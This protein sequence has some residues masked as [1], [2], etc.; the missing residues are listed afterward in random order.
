M[1]IDEP[2]T[3]YAKQYDPAE[4]EEE[5][6]GLKPEEL[7]VDELEMDKSKQPPRSR[8]SDIPGLDLGQPEMDIKRRESEGEAKVIVESNDMD[9]DHGEREEEDM[10]AAE[11]AK[12]R[13]FEDMRKRHYEMRDVKNLLG[14]VT[15]LTTRHVVQC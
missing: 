15:L 3:P 7:A 13:K 8:E 2:K 9:L 5:M 6:S 14:L 12:H 1:K 10:S 11:R 4:D